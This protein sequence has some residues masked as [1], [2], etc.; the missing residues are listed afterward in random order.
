MILLPSVF[1]TIVQLN[2]MN[3][4]EKEIEL[5]YKN[6]LNTVVFSVNQFS[7]DLVNSWK[8]VI[9]SAIAAPE[10]QANT[11]I[12]TL[13]NNE[14]SISALIFAG[15]NGEISNSFISEG[16]T[17]I[18]DAIVR[19]LLANNAKIFNRLR[20]YKVE[21]YFKNEPLGNI[22]DNIS[23][24]VFLTNSDIARYESV[25][26]LIDA[27]EF[28]R[29]LLSP[30]I[31]EISG[32]DLQIS[33]TRGS[34]GSVITSTNDANPRDAD[35]SDDLWL[36]K[37]Y[38]IN[39]SIKGVSIDD[40]VS[41]RL[42]TNLGLL[43]LL[44][45]F[46]TGGAVF[47]YVSVKKQVEI[48]QIKSDF[49]SNVSHEL[50]TPLALISMFAETLEMG[51]VRSEEKKQEY[52]TIINKEAG[53]LSRIVN[54][55]LNF[56]RMEAGKRTYNFSQ[57]NINHL[58]DEILFTYS[59]HLKNKGFEY[60]FSKD[61]TL[62][63]QE[64]DGEAITEAVINL[65]D[66]AIKYSSDKKKIEILTFRDR[67]NVAVSVKDY[68]IGIADKDKKQIF[69]KFYRVSTGLVHNTK[70]TGLGLSL[71]KHIV[72]A[73]RGEIVIDS[74]PGKGTN[75]TIVLPLNVKER[76]ESNA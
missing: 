30:K 54:K 6:R 50:R 18:T 2:S 36:L 12:S 68:G 4:T 66:N 20:T 25:I 27:D 45:I 29:G 3:E 39:I 10:E 26:L 48:T 11:K 76:E 24:L 47:L 37:D 74:E 53:R 64:C 69:E 59:F 73:H 14:S 42:Y 71:V 52:Y 31:Q 19:E 7:E 58:I 34:G 62:P 61:E 33:V 28:V 56:S 57:N 38:N 43:L 75:F 49:V 8:S 22:T 46:I 67:D 65:I 9:N 51:R 15:S 17:D 44:N 72:D 35:L 13:V 55:I 63:Y 41:A 5:I 16:I 70:G 21:E 60:T 40:L 1:F 23:A 32:Q